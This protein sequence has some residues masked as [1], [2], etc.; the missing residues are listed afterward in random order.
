MSDFLESLANMVMEKPAFPIV[1]RMFLGEVGGE[2]LLPLW[3]AP[4]TLLALYLRVSQQYPHR[5][6]KGYPFIYKIILLARQMLVANY[7]FQT[8][9]PI[10]KTGSALMPIKFPP[11]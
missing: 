5:Y 8:S 6:H 3:I 2:A 4:I 9:S 11:T 10:M 1:A 7:L